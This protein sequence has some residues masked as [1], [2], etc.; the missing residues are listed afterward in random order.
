MAVPSW[1]ES[2]LKRTDD[3]KE[4]HVREAGKASRQKLWFSTSFDLPIS[5][6]I[7]AGDAYRS[8]V[9]TREAE[10]NKNRGEEVRRRTNESGHPERVVCTSTLFDET[11]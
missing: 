11:E 8:G 7:R 5:S 6:L 3:R 4:A 1:L 10:K 9:T 2:Q